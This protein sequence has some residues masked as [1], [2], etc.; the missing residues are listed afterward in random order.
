[1]SEIDHAGEAREF[2][3]IL[4]GRGLDR[5]T[6]SDVRYAVRTLLA[7]A[8]EDVTREGLLETP[9]RVRKA[10]LGEW[11]AGLGTD[12]SIHLDKTFG[13]ADGYDEIVLVDNIR[14]ESFCEHHLAPIIGVVHIAYL[15]GGEDKRVVGLSK[16]A[17]VV[18]G[19]AKRPQVQER[20]TSQIA[21]AIAG[22][23]HAEAVAVV[24]RAEHFCM[25]TRGVHKPGAWTTT[26]CLLGRAKEDPA[27][28]AE[29]LSLMPPPPPAGR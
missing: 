21:W 5:P 8:G 28:R 22:K 2:C 26:S 13:D 7:A 17:R 18:D 19:Y 14:L 9:E 6:D 16:L 29:I 25:S 27:L 10:Y 20:L 15:P 24:I 1:M 23:L 4:R 12:P 3:G 11:L